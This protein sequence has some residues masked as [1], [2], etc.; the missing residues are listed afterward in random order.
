MSTD[1]TIKEIWAWAS[2]SQLLS[3]VITLWVGSWCLYKWQTRHNFKYELVSCVIKDVT[4]YADAAV[5]YWESF[6]NGDMQARRFNA[7]K[8]KSGLPYLSELIDNMD[9]FKEKE[10]VHVA[11][12][13]LYDIATGGAFET[14]D[15]QQRKI[16]NYQIGQ[17]YLQLAIAKRTIYCEVVK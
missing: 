16:A 11:I 1:L 6:I 4:T 9:V 14:A 17:I 7:D 8:V 5:A 13:L 3:T 15:E 10:N 2:A 12:G